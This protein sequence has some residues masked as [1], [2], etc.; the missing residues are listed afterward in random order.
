[1]IIRPKT[2]AHSAINRNWMK[3]V[4]KVAATLQV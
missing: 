1:M 2:S 4:M 3:L